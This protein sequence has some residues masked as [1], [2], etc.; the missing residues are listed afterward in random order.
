MIHM[1]T[2]LIVVTFLASASAGSLELIIPALLALKDVAAS[3][4]LLSVL[5]S[6]FSPDDKLS[7]K[8]RFHNQ[9]ELVKYLIDLITH[10]MHPGRGLRNNG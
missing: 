8:K 9:S 6:Y 4:L 7:C 10:L 2:Q 1:M 3:S 5:E